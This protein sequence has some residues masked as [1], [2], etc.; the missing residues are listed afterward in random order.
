MNK[1]LLREAVLL[2]KLAKWD[3]EK[4]IK[5]LNE[6]GFNVNEVKEFKIPNTPLTKSLFYYKAYKL[7]LEL[8]RK[9]SKL[10]I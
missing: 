8:K 7:T 5:A 2:M 3:E 6:L 1:Q 9:I 10:W 4:I